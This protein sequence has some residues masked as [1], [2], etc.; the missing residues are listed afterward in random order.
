MYFVFWQNT[1]VCQF[2]LLLGS[3]I[4]IFDH[5]FVVS[6]MKSYNYLWKLNFRYHAYIC[7]HFSSQQLVSQASTSYFSCQVKVLISL[8]LLIMVKQPQSC[9]VMFSNVFCT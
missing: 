6:S 8:F 9:T 1:N 3:L 4:D 7:D 2:D 5:E